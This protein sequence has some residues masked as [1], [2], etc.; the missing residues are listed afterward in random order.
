MLY[1]C[2]R[3]PEP[4]EFH[5]PID[6]RELPSVILLT[7]SNRVVVSHSFLAEGSKRWLDKANHG[8]A[9]GGEGGGSSKR[10]IYIYIHIVS[11]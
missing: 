8:R 6:L 9:R 11:R 3:Y 4:V 10:Y 1:S 2:V 7:K 5:S